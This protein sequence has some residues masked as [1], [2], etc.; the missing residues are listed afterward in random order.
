MRSP[1]KPSRQRN[2]CACETVT[3]WFASGP[4]MN[5]TGAYRTRSVKTGPKSS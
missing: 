5:T 3:K 1:M 4:I 2:R